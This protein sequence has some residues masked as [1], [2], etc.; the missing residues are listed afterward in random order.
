VRRLRYLATAAAILA[1][2]A[3]FGVLGTASATTLCGV[4]PEKVEGKSLCPAGQKVGV[5]IMSGETTEGKLGEKTVAE[6][7]SE[8]GTITCNESSFLGAFN[9]NGTSPAT[10]GITKMS[11]GDSKSTKC[12]STLSGKPTVEVKMEGL[13][14]NKTKIVREKEE[15]PQSTLTIA[16]EKGVTMKLTFLGTECSYQPE[17]TLNATY[18]DPIGES[19]GI[20][21]M[22]GK[23]LKKTAGGESCPG[24]WRWWWPW[25]LCQ[26]I[27]N[28]SLGVYVLTYSWSLW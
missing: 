27:W 1:I 21:Q 25:R 23:K 5:D 3:L 18:A 15:S 22:S 14:Y 17:E 2:T 7:E 10:G 8:K 26:N 24:W 16:G 9:S 20:A 12:P 28:S 19:F 4:K 6:I 13:P 11:F